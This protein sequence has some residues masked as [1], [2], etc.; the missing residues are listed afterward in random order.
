[1]LSFFFFNDTATTEIYTLSLH[2]ALPICVV[3]AEDARQREVAQRGAVDTPCGVGPAELDRRRADDDGEVAGGSRDAR[4]GRRG[5]SLAPARRERERRQEDAR[6]EACAGAHPWAISVRA[7][8]SVRRTAA[9]AVP[10]VTARGRSEAS[11]AIASLTSPSINREEPR[12]PGS[13]RSSSVLPS[14][15]A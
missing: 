6:G 5:R 15:R 8:A 14:S 7:R 9:G 3:H 2:D 4:L 1:M 11:T 12:N 13:V 10:P